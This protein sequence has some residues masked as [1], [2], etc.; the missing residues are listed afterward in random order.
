MT[1]RRTVGRS[2]SWRDG[3]IDGGV[4]NIPIVFLKKK[5]GENNLT[6]FYSALNILQYEYSYKNEN[7]LYHLVL[8]RF[9]LNEA[10]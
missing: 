1:K 9:I 8:Y 3:R 10:I 2:D 4:N 7:L 5:R 6:Y